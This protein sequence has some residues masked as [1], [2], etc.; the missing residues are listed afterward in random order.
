MDY[1]IQ[2]EA[3]DEKFPVSYILLD[4]D[5]NVEVKLTDGKSDIMKLNKNTKESRNFKLC[6]QW[7]ELDAE[8]AS[9]LELKLK[10]DVVQSKEGDV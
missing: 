10:V 6:L 8:L 3:S 4:C 5:N 7:K 9:K 2:I 1:Y